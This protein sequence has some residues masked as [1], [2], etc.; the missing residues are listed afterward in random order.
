MRVSRRN[1]PSRIKV[2][3]RELKELVHFKF[4]RSLLTTNAY[5]RRKIERIP[6]IAKEAF[7]RKISLLTNKLNIKHRNKLVRKLEWEYLESWKCGGG[8]EWSR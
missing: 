8:G 3:N 5:C 2:G 1:K 4:R 6:V 7:D